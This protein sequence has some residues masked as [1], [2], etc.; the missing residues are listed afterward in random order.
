[1]RTRQIWVTFLSAVL[2]GCVPADQGRPP[3]REP[4]PAEPVGWDI[5][6]EINPAVG[7]WLSYYR[8]RGRES[9]EI[10]L[11]R[12]GRYERV[13]REIFRR[14]GL[15]EDLIYLSL[16]ESGFRPT[17]Y[18]RAR[19]AGLWQFVP[20]T[21]RLYGLEMSHWVDE[22]LDPIAATE[23]A[24]EYLEDLH[25]EFRDW[26]LTLAA[27]NAGPGRVHR[28]IRRTG[29]RD[30]WALA[31][32]RALRWETRNYVPK[33]IAV[34]LIAKLPE[35]YGIRVRPEPIATFD[36]RYVPDAT[37]LDV[38]AE[39]A[40]V[41]FDEIL[42]LNLHLVRGVTPP[43]ERYAVRLPAG[44]ARIF[45]ENYA[46][47]PPSDRVR[48]VVHVVRRGENLERIARI[49]GSRVSAIREVNGGIDPRSLKAGQRLLIPQIRRL[50]GLAD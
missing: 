23:A 8:D 34:A 25:R 36:I 40:G 50:P 1:M 13:M 47:L 12:A 38:V 41:P 27:Y 48:S 32:N 24:A 7:R 5:P 49:Y 22:R 43:G 3:D 45:A 39:A 44:T 28:A 42:E 2:L 19:A 20:N 37:S 31:E 17:A 21:A 11:T 15:P 9:F 14:K 4:P 29:S 6:I 30:F 33:L 46:K 10:A 16:I 26:Y 35:E 18:S